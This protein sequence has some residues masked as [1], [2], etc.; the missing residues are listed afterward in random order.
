LETLVCAKMACV[1]MDCTKSSA[2]IIFFNAF[3]LMQF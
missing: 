3:D 1:D 2:T